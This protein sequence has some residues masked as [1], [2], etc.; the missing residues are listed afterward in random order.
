MSVAESPPV[1]SQRIHARIR[2]FRRNQTLILLFELAFVAT[3]VCLI[4]HNVGVF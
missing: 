2:R 3:G 4:L 1:R